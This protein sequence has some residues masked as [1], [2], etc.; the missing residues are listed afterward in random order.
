[1]ISPLQLTVEK[2]ICVAVK[3]IDPVLVDDVFDTLIAYVLVD[4][5]DDVLRMWP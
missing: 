3:Y 5:R 4:R 1:M 2:N